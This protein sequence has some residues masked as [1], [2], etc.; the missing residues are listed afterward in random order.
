[1]HAPDTA[2]VPPDAPVPSRSPGAGATPGEPPVP[3][4]RPPARL[5]AASRAILEAPG[6]A[7]LYLDLMKRCLT[8][9]I[10]E[11]DDALRSQPFS[12]AQRAEGRDW[13]ARAH[14]MVGLKRLDNVQRCVE[15][16]LRDGV[17]GDLIET[18]VWR[19]GT[20]IFMRAILAAH[21]DRVRRVWAADSFQ[22]LPPPDPERYPSDAGDTF[23]TYPQLAISLEQVKEN[24]RRYGL[25]DERVEFLV[26][27]F[28]DTLPGSRTGP[29]AVARLDG[30][31]YESTMDALVSL[32]PRLSPGGWL[33][34]DDYGAVPACRQAVDDYRA[35]KG[36]REP[37]EEVDW[38]CVCWRRTA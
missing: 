22:G 3:A 29:L 38:T 11:D 28:K 31:M 4:G 17:P 9:L 26:G 8:N 10:Y 14:T 6:G 1:M 13:P 16:V 7:A 32:Y 34:V 19:G 27:W 5:D 33:I 30:D 18:G 36:I 12:M 37:L 2:R 20:A 25:L 23:H 15:E 35:G 24:F 21:G